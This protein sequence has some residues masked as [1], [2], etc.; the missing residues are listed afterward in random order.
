MKYFAILLLTLLFSA[1]FI[2]F[3]ENSLQEYSIPKLKLIDVLQDDQLSSQNINKRISRIII[4]DIGDLT[5]N[6][7]SDSIITPNLKKIS[8]ESRSYSSTIN[9]SPERLN[10]LKSFIECLPSYKLNDAKEPFLQYKNIITKELR[11]SSVFNEYSKHDYI[12]K[13]FTSDSVV[14]TE[15]HKY[16]SSS[17]KLKSDQEVLEA[18]YRDIQKDIS[19][20]FIY[21]A[22][23]SGGIKNNNYIRDVDHFIGQLTDKIEEKFNN[24]DIMYLFISTA[25]SDKYAKTMS[26]FYKDKKAAF[27]ESLDVAV[28]DIAKT[29][30]NYSNI[31]PP[32]Y[33]GGYDLENEDDNLD[34]EYFAGSSADT[35]L[36]F[37]DDHIFKKQKYSEHYSYYDL[38]QNKDVS[39]KF[40]GINEKFVEIIPRY[41]G[42]DYIK[43]IILR[44]RG[45]KVKNFKFEIRSKRRFEEL[46]CL[47]NYYTQKK[48][49]NRYS[50]EINASLEPGYVDTVK[51]YYSSLY[52]SFD[53]NFNDKYEL[54][55][56]SSGINAGSLKDFDENSYY[57]MRYFY[58]DEELFKDYDIRIYN[59]RINY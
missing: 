27:T 55:Y 11:N 31:R 37:D 39:D 33:F 17:Q 9:L 29:L 50:K 7:I 34:R 45:D 14:F 5:G 21:Y 23:I 24:P 44:N 51:I 49:R 57:G 40:I 19:T 20:D 6:S 16:F 25:R 41:F 56:G 18:L 2:L 59:M 58:T 1:A 47:D 30:L 36:L 48:D 4:F 42:G 26:F 22:D 15:I 54:S 38:N 13:C 35:L 46:S 8:A 43:Y 52:Q 10:S 32:N 12:T 28:T 3:R 53:Y